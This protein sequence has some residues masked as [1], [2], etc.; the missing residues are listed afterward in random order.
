MRT[1]ETEPAWVARVPG[2]EESIPLLRRQ[3]RARLSAL[4]SDPGDLLL[5]LTEIA[6]NAL[7]HTDSGR[8]GKIVV[9]LS[10][11]D[12]E[13]TLLVTDDGGASTCPAI[14]NRPSATSGR[15]LRLVDALAASW[16][17]RFGEPGNTVWF[18]FPR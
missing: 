9:W 13:I 15:G 1:S 2:V 17:V 12:Q 10:T 6:T 4:V 14:T 16:G 8:G 3:A 7:R 18:T 11:T 5:C